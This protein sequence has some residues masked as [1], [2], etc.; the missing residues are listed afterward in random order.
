MP[1]LFKSSSLR[2]LSEA[3]PPAWSLL[4]QGDSEAWHSACLLDTARSSY[5]E[6]S[7]CPI[8]MRPRVAARRCGDEGGRVLAYALRRSSRHQ[9]VEVPAKFTFLSDR[10]SPF[11]GPLNITGLHRIFADTE[12][13][14][15]GI[16]QFANRYG[17]LGVDFRNPLENQEQNSAA[18]VMITR[19][20]FA[21]SGRKFRSGPLEPSNWIDTKL[22]ARCD[23]DA[24]CYCC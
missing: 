20:L 13:T 4:L 12:P 22:L 15:Q 17:R 3:L 24:V 8:A 19:L 2:P 10:R 7:S 1:C 11:L 5:L 6:C 14:L 23:M 9:R 18:T 16:R 21:M